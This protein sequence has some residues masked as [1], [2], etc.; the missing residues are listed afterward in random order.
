MSYLLNTWYV[1]AWDHEVILEKPLARKILDEELVFFRGIDGSPKAI[2]NRCPHRF[3]PLSKGCVKGNNIQCAYHGLEFDGNGKCVLN[4]HG[5]GNIP[6]Q[7]KVKAYSVVERFS[8]IWIWMGDIDKADPDKIPDY[9]QSLDPE[10]RYIAKD[11][12]HARANYQLETDNIMDLSHI[13]FLH[14][15]SLGSDAIK[16]A[17]TEV[18]QEGNTVYSNRLTKNERLHES[19]EKRYN[20]PEGQLVD[21][22]LDV[23]WDPPANMELWV[24]IA[25]SGTENPRQVGKR[26]PFNHFFTPE[27]NKTAHYWFSTSYPRRMGD[28]GLRRANE[29]IKYLRG[30]FETED[31]PMLEAQQNLMGDSDFWSLKPILLAGDAAA[32]RARRVLDQ[33]IKDEQ[34]IN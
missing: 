1:A 33:L 14:P 10:K 7:A 26:I 34:N 30:P 18:T 6:S 8:I 9:S 17:D 29:D 13:E 23:R 32:V 2:H 15:G 27:T 3:A 16:Q 28:E 24:G 20:I 4:P 21:R 5:K 25:P 22:W 12:L 19:L 11:Y 31:L